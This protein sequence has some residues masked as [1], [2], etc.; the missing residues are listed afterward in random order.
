MAAKMKSA[1]NGARARVQPRCTFLDWWAGE[2]ACAS[3]N[4]R[5]VSLKDQ[6]A[7]R[8]SCECQRKEPLVPSLGWSNEIQ[9]ETRSV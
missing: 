9:R 4:A 3:E 7:V 1:K 2:Q 6:I 8:C 5:S